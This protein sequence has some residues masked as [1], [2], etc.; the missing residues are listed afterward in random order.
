MHRF[1]APADGSLL[2]VLKDENI[3]DT[4]KEVAYTGSLAWEAEQSL[5]ELKPKSSQILKMF[6]GIGLEHP[7][8]A[9]ANQR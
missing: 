5:S 3:E 9:G 8:V 7:D 4:D 6:F 1:R 2:D